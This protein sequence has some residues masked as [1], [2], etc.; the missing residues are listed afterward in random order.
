MGLLR[1]TRWAAGHIVRGDWR[2]VAENLQMR[3]LGLDYA[4]AEVEEMGLPPERAHRHGSSHV[5]HLRPILKRLRI[6]PTDAIIDLGCGKWRA[7]AI[8]ARFP[9]RRIAGVELSPVVAQIARANLRKLGLDRIEV[10]D[11]DAGRFEALDDFSHAFM[12]DPFPCNVVAEVTGNLQRSLSRRPR[13]LTV[14]YANPVCHDVLTGS[15][16]FT[17]VVDRRDA[18]IAH[19]IYVVE[20]P[21]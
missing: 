17:T 4:L 20:G 16:V 9:F 5:M 6:G 11:G 12:F 15:G 21:A 13:R 8:M 2:E 3:R 10:F 14:V 18:S 19:V 7:L 1:F